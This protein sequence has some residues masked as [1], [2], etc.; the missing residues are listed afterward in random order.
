MFM[1]FFSS[2]IRPATILDLG[3][4]GCVSSLFS[5]KISFQ[6]LG[7]FLLVPSLSRG[8]GVLTWRKAGT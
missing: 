7:W 5:S 4:V 6:R 2:K 1:H 8:R 3:H